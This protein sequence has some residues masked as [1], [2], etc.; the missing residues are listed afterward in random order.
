MFS[1]NEKDIVN[2]IDGIDIVIGN[3]NKIKIV[4]Y[5]EEYINNN[6]PIVEIKILLMNLKI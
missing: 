5:I 1:S 6:R 4:D 3:K 2:K